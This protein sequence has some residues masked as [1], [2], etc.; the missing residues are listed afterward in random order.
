MISPFRAAEIS[1]MISLN[2]RDTAAIARAMIGAEDYQLHLERELDWARPRLAVAGVR[3]AE[4]GCLPSGSLPDASLPGGIRALPMPP[5]SPT[6]ILDI[7]IDLES[8]SGEPLAMLRLVRVPAS[9]TT[10]DRLKGL[11]HLRLLL[12]SQIDALSGGPAVVAATMLHLVT[13]MRELDDNAVSHSLCGLLHVLAGKQPSRVEVMAMRICGL[14]ATPTGRHES[15]EVVLSDVARDLLEQAGLG[16]AQDQVAVIAPAAEEAPLMEVVRPEFLAPF[17]R[18]RIVE[19][20]YD[21]AEDD[22]T[23]HLWFRST[24][25]QNDWSPLANTPADGWAAIAAEILGQTTDIFVD[26]AQMHLIRRRDLPTDQVAE[27]YDL[28]GTVW[29]VREGETGIEARLADGAWRPCDID[30]DL[31]A[32]KRALQAL[33]R[34]EP[35]VA[36][37]LSGHFNDWARR[38]SQAVQV[39]PYMAVAAE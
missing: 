23:G 17:A 31:P 30:G 34:I 8:A 14:A 37:R 2:I 12:K 20:D 4:R 33:M 10:R 22:R 1:D 7:A 21:V 9:W 3:L 32:K 38:M 15:H 13:L 24:A 36:E 39:V 19:Q 11:V 6:D 16:R 26:Y 25:L 28:N 5:G 18:A 29:W 27:A 35:D